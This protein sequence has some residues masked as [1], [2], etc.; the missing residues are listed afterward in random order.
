MFIYNLLR[1]VPTRHQVEHGDA[2]KRKLQQVRSRAQKVKKLN[3]YFYPLIS[4]KPLPSISSN[5]N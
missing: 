3:V 2:H 1:F 5:W 4:P